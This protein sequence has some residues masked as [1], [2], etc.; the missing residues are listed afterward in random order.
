MGQGA[1][2]GDRIGYAVKRLQQAQRVAMDAVLAHLGLSMAQVAAL[3]FLLDGELSSAELAR[4]AFTTR[5]SM[6]DVLGCLRDRQ[7]V[8]PA[9]GSE[10][11]R[12]RPLRLTAAGT[13][14]ARAAYDAVK[15]VEDQMTRGLTKTERN[16]LV[17]WLDMCTDN[18]RHRT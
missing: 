8:E 11:G 12:S 14:A 16:Q 1:P 3:E 7:L 17:R 10:H 15:E 2:V 5:Q 13:A 18:L 9:T 4:R 6:Q